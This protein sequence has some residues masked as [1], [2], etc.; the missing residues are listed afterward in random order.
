MQKLR[1][2]ITAFFVLE[3]KN[4]V[5]TDHCAHTAAD[6]FFPVT[7]QGDH[8]FQIVKFRHCCS[9]YPSHSNAVHRPI[10]QTMET[11]WAGIARS[12][13]FLTPLSEVKVEGP[14]GPWAEW[15]LAAHSSLVHS[16]FHV[17]LYHR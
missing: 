7:F 8:I 14:A 11:N 4:S 3:D 16:C 10:P 17:L 9:P 13:S 5:R 2:F 15:S 6:T 1:L 12:I